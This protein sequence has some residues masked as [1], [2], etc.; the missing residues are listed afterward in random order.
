MQKYE[1]QQ[2]E[3]CSQQKNISETFRLAGRRYWP[4]HV[5]AFGLQD[6][7]QIGG[8]NLFATCAWIGKC[9]SQRTFKSRGKTVYTLNHVIRITTMSE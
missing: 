1:A 4:L 9:S 5:F 7:I 6:R 3:R 8:Q 2:K